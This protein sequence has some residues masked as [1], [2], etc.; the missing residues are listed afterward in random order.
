VLRALSASV[1]HAFDHLL[2]ADGVVVDVA[3]VHEG[4]AGHEAVLAAGEAVSDVALGEDGA[5]HALGVALQLECLL[6]QRAFRG[7]K[8]ALF[9]VGDLVV[10]RLHDGMEFIDDDVQQGVRQERG[11]VVQ[12]QCAA[13]GAPAHLVDGADRRL[14]ERDDVVGADVEVEFFGGQLESRRVVAGWRGR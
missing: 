8:R 12:D 6:Q 14:V 5:A 11:P 3:E 7:I 13:F 9:E 2:D 1:A 10:K 4:I